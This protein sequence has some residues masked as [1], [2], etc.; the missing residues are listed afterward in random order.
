[1]KKYN[2]KFF[3]YIN[4]YYKYLL[5]ELFKY[6]LRRVFTKIFILEKYVF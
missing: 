3:F 2:N 6:G 4:I 5:L 1:M